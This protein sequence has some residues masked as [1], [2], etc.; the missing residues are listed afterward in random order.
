M[1]LNVLK[2]RC[3]AKFCYRRSFPLVPHLINKQGS[4]A[5][6][7]RKFIN[8]VAQEYYALGALDLL[9]QAIWRTAIR[10]GIPVDAAVAVPDPTWITTLLKT[11]L[12]GAQIGYAYRE[13]RR[14]EHVKVE[15]NGKVIKEYDQ[16][17]DFEQDAKF[18]GLREVLN[19]PAGTR[20]EK[21][22]VANMFGYSGP[23]AW[24]GNKGYILGLLDGFVAESDDG[25]GLIRVG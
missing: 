24:K 19:A 4:P 16:V 21:C 12:P 11:V 6:S 20:F 25:K 1:L 13:N 23:E 18:A 3:A 14:V 5:M 22:D 10:N 17:W 9:Y 8:P 7:Q 2:I 15:H